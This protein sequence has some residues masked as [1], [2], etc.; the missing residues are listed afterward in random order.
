MEDLGEV[1]G[2]IILILFVIAV[3]IGTCGGWIYLFHI[4]G[5]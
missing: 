1:M 4:L 5:V 3:I 2:I